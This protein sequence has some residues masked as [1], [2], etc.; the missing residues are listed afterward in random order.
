MDENRVANLVRHLRAWELDGL[1]TSLL[2]VSSP[3]AVFGAQALYFTQPF[4]A[5]FAAESEVTALARWLENPAA[6]HHL[7]RRL[8]QEA[9]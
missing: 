1:A 4:L 3:L 6:L 9:E 7:A 5:P 2:E 8:A